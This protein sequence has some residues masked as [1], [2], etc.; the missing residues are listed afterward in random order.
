MTSSTY[1]L[2]KFITSRDKH[3]AGNCDNGNYTKHKLLYPVAFHCYSIVSSA[4]LVITSSRTG[5]SPFRVA[6]ACDQ[7]T[8][9]RPPFVSSVEAVGMSHRG[10]TKRGSALALTT[11]C[12]PLLKFP[13]FRQNDRFADSKLI[14]LA[15]RYSA[16]RLT[17]I[18]FPFFYDI[19]KLRVK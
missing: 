14:R 15:V 12:R 1:F 19:R 3:N 16:C 18:G 4:L 11:R 7:D 6:F 9:R 8:K 13:T 17:G 5:H 2:T 10:N